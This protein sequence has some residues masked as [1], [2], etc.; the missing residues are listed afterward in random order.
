MTE[1]L[2]LLLCPLLLRLDPPYSFLPFLVVGYLPTVAN[3]MSRFVPNANAPLRMWFQ[4]F[5]RCLDL[6]ADG[7]NL[8]ILMRMGYRNIHRDVREQTCVVVYRIETMRK[9]TCFVLYRIETTREHICLSFIG[10]KRQLL[11]DHR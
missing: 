11:L 5:R 1:Y 8:H 6:R 4:A 9:Q 7:R 3:T 2:H 10:L